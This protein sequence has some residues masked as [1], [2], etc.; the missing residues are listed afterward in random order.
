MPLTD[1]LGEA[2]SMEVAQAVH[3]GLR[4]RILR[5]KEEK[6]PEPLTISPGEVGALL[7]DCGVGEDKVSAFLAQCGERFGE[8]AV[9]SPANLIDSGKFELKTAA[10]HPLH[11]PGT[12]LPGGAAHHRRAQLFAHPRGGGRGA[13]PASASAPPGTDPQPFL[14][15]R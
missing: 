7:A 3:E 6:D 15:Y 11:R 13:Q 14:L 10:R 12:E 5:H 2:C 9:L 4:E 8:G 1:A